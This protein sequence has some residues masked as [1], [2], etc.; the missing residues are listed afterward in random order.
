M[1]AFS[2]MKTSSSK[3]VT[4]GNLGKHEKSMKSFRIIQQK[5]N[6]VSNISAIS[7]NNGK[8]YDIRHIHH[9][10]NE[11]G[12]SRVNAG[13]YKMTKEQVLQMLDKKNKDKKNKDKKKDMKKDTKKSINS[14]S[15]VKPSKLIVKKS[16]KSE[17]TKKPKSP[18]KSAMKPKSPSK[19][20]K[21]PKSSMK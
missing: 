6:N 4:D 12:R 11:N 14:N 5:N 3:I 21:K 20:A 15:P 17:S 16:T 2:I 1:P 19:S 9:R 7:T 10:L 18:S 13:V 8:T